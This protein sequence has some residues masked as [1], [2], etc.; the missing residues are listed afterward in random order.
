M[1]RLRGWLSDHEPVWVWVARIWLANVWRRFVTFRG[2]SCDRCYD[3]RYVY[4]SRSMRA[5]ATND[6]DEHRRCMGCIGFARLLRF[7]LSTTP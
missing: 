6:G 3:C 4:P 1:K 2:Q 5:I 7:A